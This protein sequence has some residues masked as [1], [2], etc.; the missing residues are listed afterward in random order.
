[1]E[2]TM[3]YEDRREVHVKIDINIDSIDKLV[4]IVRNISIIEKEYNSNCTQ[5]QINIV[6]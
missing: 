3:R 4:N 5:I 1:M 6:D 2:K